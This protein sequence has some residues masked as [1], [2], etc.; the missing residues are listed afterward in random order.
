MTESSRCGTLKN[1]HCLWS[2]VVLRIYNNSPAMVTFQYEQQI[3]NGNKEHK[4]NKPS[5]YTGTSYLKSTGKKYIISSN[6]EGLP[7]DLVSV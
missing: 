2:R 6:V 5:E 3:M 1:S 7:L 4:T